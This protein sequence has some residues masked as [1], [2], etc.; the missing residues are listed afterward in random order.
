MIFSHLVMILLYGII[1]VNFPILR[2]LTI[3]TI[4]YSIT[5]LILIAN[6]HHLYNI[7]DDKINFKNYKS[8]IKIIL[9]LFIAITII[10]GSFYL[11][12]NIS[13]TSFLVKKQQMTRQNEVSKNP[14]IFPGHP[15]H[16][17]VKK[18]YLEKNFD[19]MANFR[20]NK[21]ENS[22][23]KELYNEESKEKLRNNP[24]IKGLSDVIMV[25]IGIMIALL[26]SYKNKKPDE[27]QPN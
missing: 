12:K 2:N 16:I 11:I 20:Q 9:A 3:A 17:N 4:V 22:K 19:N 13:I 24:A 21:Y 27:I 26:L 15:V 10:L 25:I 5:T 18:Y 7:R 6:S 8:S 1:I 14:L 23:E